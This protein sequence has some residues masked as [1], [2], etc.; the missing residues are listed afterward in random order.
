[1][2]D[3]NLLVL[4]KEFSKL[5]REVRGVLA[6]PIG[7]QGEKGDAREPGLPGA[8]GERGTDGKDGRDGKDGL[9]GLNG[10][11]GKPGKDG[12]NGKDGADGVSVVDAEIAA[13]GN[14]VF[15]LSD[16]KIIDA[17]ELPT[18]SGTNAGVFVSGNAAQITVSSTAPANPQLNQLWYDIS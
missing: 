4:A 2:S 14:L 18:G 9:I 15:K 5:R 1:M 13:D 12:R 11:N 16:G 17:G 10:V 7:P 3:T 6:L 8:K